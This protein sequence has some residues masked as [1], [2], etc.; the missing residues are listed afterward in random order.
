M[1]GELQRILGSG[2]VLFAVATPREFAA[3]AEGLGNRGP[4]GEPWRLM[5]LGWADGV[6]TGVGKANA[7]GGVARVLDPSRHGCVVCIGVAGTLRESG[8]GLGDVV[9]ASHSVFAEEGIETPGGFRTCAE[10]GF[11]LGDTEG[12]AVA[13]DGAIGAALG[14][15][16]QAWGRIATV[17]TCS[18]TDAL[19]ARVAERTGAIAEAMEGAGAGL[20]AVR[21]GVRFGEVRVI[22][23]TTG[24][25]AR[26]AW[27]L[28][29]ALDRMSGYAEWMKG[30]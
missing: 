3:L 25:R 30:G 8:P 18:G 28:R 10:M 26:Q 24:D 6:V 22:S 17:S 16:A 11:P 13:C 4:G 23:N 27:D 7:A 20:A 9:V 5:E 29:G 12:N 19:R 2:R 14:R 1:R 15:G 21:L